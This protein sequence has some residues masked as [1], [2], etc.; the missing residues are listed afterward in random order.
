VACAAICSRQGD[1]KALIAYSSVVHMGLVG[2]GL[3]MCRE[4]GRSCALMM[5]IAHGVCSPMIF[6]YAFRLYKQVH[7]RLLCLGRRGLTCPAA[8]TLLCLLLLVNLGVPPSLNLCRE[9]AGYCAILPYY[10]SAA[11]ALPAAVI[12]GILYNLVA[13]VG[14][15]HGKETASSGD[16]PRPHE[17]LVRLALSL[18]LPL[19]LGI[20]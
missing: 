20:F 4:L 8:S 11:A 15:T 17:Y 14:L 9:V 6:S 3:L 10:F 19:D 16:H 1:L 2:V 5:V 18:V 12:F 7:R 13:Y